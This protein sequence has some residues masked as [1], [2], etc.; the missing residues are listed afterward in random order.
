MLKSIAVVLVVVALLVAVWQLFRGDSRVFASGK[1]SMRSVLVEDEGISFPV[2]TGSA[3]IGDL[4]REQFGGYA[5]GDEIFPTPEKRIVGGERVVIRRMKGVRLTVDGKT[6]DVTTTARTASEMLRESGIT[7]AEDDFIL[8]DGEMPLKD[9]QTIEVVRVVVKESVEHESLPFEKIEK[10]DEKM[11]WRERSVTQK[12]VKGELEKKY[13]IVSHNGK[14]VR[15]ALVSQT[16]V[17]EPID[18]IATQGTLV[19]TGKKH[20]GLGTWYSFTG[21][22]AAASPWLP[23]GSY[24]KVTNKANGKSVMVRINDRG[25]F[26]KN[27][28]IDLDKVA[29]EKIASIGA[30]IIDVSVEEVVN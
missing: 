17:K 6:K 25:P 1:T 15:K 3:T 21:T 7:I 28:I 27:R 18:E 8:P 20:T 29:F 16:V 2:L 10:N 11:G 30:G 24:A 26:G 4:L 19:K 13:R 14:I 23:M 9:E 22:L 5:Q 12:G